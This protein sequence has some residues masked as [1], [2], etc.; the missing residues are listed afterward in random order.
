MDKVSIRRLVRERRHGLDPGTA[1]RAGDSLADPFLLSR[2][3]F[4]AAHAIAGYLSLPGE[5]PPEPLMELLHATG[6]IVAVPA[7]DAA[8]GCYGFAEWGPREP[9]AMG[10]C[11]V[12]QPADPRFVPFESLDAVLVPG[13]AFDRSGGRVGFGGG[14][15]DRLLSRCRADAV[16]VAL[17]FEW[18]FIPSVPLEP[19]DMPMDAF[20]LPGPG[21]FPHTPRI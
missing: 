9:L 10:P 14:W 3:P 2:P 20:L 4:A 6:R 15:Y 12:L 8:H 7:W 19:H 17:A 11:R 1:E 13:L 16:R 5:L 21:L 18:Q